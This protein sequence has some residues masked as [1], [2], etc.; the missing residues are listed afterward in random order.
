MSFEKLGDTDAAQRI[1]DRL[2][3]LKPPTWDHNW[4]CPN[5]KFCND[6]GFIITRRDEYGRMYSK[7]CEPCLER[8]KAELAAKTPAKTPRA[9][10][11]R[12]REE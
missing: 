3:K 12:D 1:L 11:K 6:T 4:K 5:G 2:L 8:E 9:W 10:T 7:R